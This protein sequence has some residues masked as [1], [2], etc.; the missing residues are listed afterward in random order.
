MGTGC[1]FCDCSRSQ[2]FVTHSQGEVTSAPAL[3]FKV[4][5]SALLVQFFS[6]KIG[7]NVKKSKVTP[8][9]SEGEIVEFHFEAGQWVDF[10]VPSVETVGGFSIVSTMKKYNESGLVD[11]AV[12]VSCSGVENEKKLS[13]RC[14]FAH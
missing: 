3:S 13:C 8:Q 5:I 12:K 2:G 11:L 14:L 7:D 10:F 1:L 4:N 6:L 9:E